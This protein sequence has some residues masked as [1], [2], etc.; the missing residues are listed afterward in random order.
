MCRVRSDGCVEVNEEWGFAGE[1]FLRLAVEGA[2]V[3]RPDD[4]GPI[5]AS[6]TATLAEVTARCDAGLREQATAELP[7]YIEALRIAS[8][9]TEFAQHVGDVG[10]HGEQR[11]A[12][13][14]SDVRARLAVG[15]Q[16]G[17]ASF[18]R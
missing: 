17:D 11:Q 7:K 9:G 4:A 18:D 15:Q 1:V 10:L 2:L 16:C 3:L 13:L 8:S 14:Q 5:I 6:L 12:E